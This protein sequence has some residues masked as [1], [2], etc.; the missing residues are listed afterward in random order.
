MI[1]N[2]YIVKKSLYDWSL[3]YFTDIT[4]TA[5]EDRTHYSILK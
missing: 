4:L 2:S 5:D 1:V 3:A